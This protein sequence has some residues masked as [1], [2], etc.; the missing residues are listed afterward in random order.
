VGNTRNAYQILFGKFE[1]KRDHL[2]YLEGVDWAPLDQDR[3]Q[4]RA[5]V[6]TVMNLWVI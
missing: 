4:L 3:V 5:F 6:N 1:G 2:G